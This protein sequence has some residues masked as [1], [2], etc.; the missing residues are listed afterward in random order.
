MP[1]TTNHTILRGVAAN[2]EDAWRAFINF[3]HP[4]IYLCGC[5]HG[6]TPEELEDLQQ[7]VAMTI[8]NG[9]VIDK[10]DVNVG[11]FRALLRSVIHHRAIDILRRRLPPSVEIDND[12]LMEHVLNAAHSAQASSPE[13]EWQK[14]V[15]DMA[16]S[17]LREKISH[18]NY[19][20]FDLYVRQDMAPEKV[21]EM[22][23]ITLNQVYIA[24]N[25]GL[26]MLKTIVARLKKEL[27]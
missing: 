25:R 1:Y 18:T 10:Y 5:D 21:A 9:H 24:K 6:L 4:F 2:D 26:A 15:L 16:M 19:L 20:A 22:L 8:C 13:T 17:E 3:Y 27:K 14:T 7:E 11:R 23:E 12:Q